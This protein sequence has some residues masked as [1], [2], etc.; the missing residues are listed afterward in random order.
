MYNYFKNRLLILTTN[1]NDY[2]DTKRFFLLS[3][4][5]N[6]SLSLVP[7]SAMSRINN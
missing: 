2:S 5:I 3:K 7:D 4:L 1:I 6:N